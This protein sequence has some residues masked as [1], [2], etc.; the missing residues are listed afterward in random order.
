MTSLITVRVDDAATW[1]ALDPTLA[2]GEE[3]LESDTGSRK[4]GDGVRHWTQLP[5]D[6]GGQ[7]MAAALAPYVTVEQVA[8]TGG[9]TGT[10]PM[11]GRYATRPAAGA[12]MTGVTFYATDVLQGYLATGTA[13]QPATAWWPLPAS[14]VELAA[15][16][17]EA[18]FTINAAPSSTGVFTQTVFGTQVGFLMPEAPVMLTGRAIVQ[19]AFAI[20]D[21]NYTDPPLAIVDITDANNPVLLD[22]AHP[23]AVETSADFRHALTMARV[24]GPPGQFRAFELRGIQRSAGAWSIRGSATFPITLE[25]V[26]R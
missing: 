21:A 16:R 7:A 5:Y 10:A 8:T 14:G 2:L 11:L 19:M 12:V 6:V 20:T 13:G 26:T 15:A 23:G 18:G 17:R 24:T 25:A 1:A 9:L 4:T 22:E 3:G